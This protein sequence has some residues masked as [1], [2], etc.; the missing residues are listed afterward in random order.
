MY[1]VSIH[2]FSLEAYKSI[3]DLNR[4]KNTHHMP[5]TDE[6]SVYTNTS[7]GKEFLHVA[8]EVYWKKLKMK[9]PTFLFTQFQ[10]MKVLIGLWCNI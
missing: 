5:L 3:C 1:F 8:K 7:S 4:Y 10:L 9:F 6:Y 2:N